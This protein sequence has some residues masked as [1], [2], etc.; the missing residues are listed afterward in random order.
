[1]V[2]ESLQSQDDGASG[3]S[4]QKGLH[5]DP[6]GGQVRVGDAAPGDLDARNAMFS[7]H[8]IEDQQHLGVDNASDQ[9]LAE[10]LPPREEMDQI[11]E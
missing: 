7:D 8:F 2:V 1:M 9:H 4:I 10:Q 11:V 3:S 5:R 6:E